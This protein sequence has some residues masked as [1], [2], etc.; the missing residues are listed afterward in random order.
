MCVLII[1]IFFKTK[2]HSPLAFK[3]IGCKAKI[4]LTKYKKRKEVKNKILIYNFS[5]L[6]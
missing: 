1:I 6:T 4:T 3:L 2:P 5:L